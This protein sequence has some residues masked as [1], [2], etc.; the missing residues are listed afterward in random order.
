MSRD[1]PLPV[2][3]VKL[4]LVVPIDKKRKISIFRY[5]KSYSILL[6]RCF[7]GVTDIGEAGIAGVVDTGEK[8]LAGVV[9]TGK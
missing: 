2:F 7:A 6:F 1:F 4:F 8:F 5:P 3:L 9:D